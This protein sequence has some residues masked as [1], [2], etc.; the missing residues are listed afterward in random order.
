MAMNAN[1]SST[2]SP[3]PAQTLGSYL[4]R[5]QLRLI[6]QGVRPGSDPFVENCFGAILVVDV[7]G[8]TALTERFAAQGVAGAE[9]LSC[10]LNRYFGQIADIITACGGDIVAFAGDSAL[11]M[12]TG[13]H[14]D[15]A[16]NIVR[17]TQAA[18]NIQ[19]E[20]DQYEAVRGVLLRQRAGI[21]CGA[22][23]LM[24]L[25]GVS[26]R[27]QF[28][29]TGSPIAQAS[30]ANQNAQSGEVF[31]SSEAWNLVRSRVRGTPLPSGLVRATEVA[32]SEP[33]AR[34]FAEPVSTCDAAESFS[35]LSHYVPAVVADR[36]RAGQEQWIAEFRN[37]SMLF[38]NLAESRID[39]PTAVAS[40]HEHLRCIQEVLERFEGT[41]YQFL[42]DDKGLTAVCAFGLPPQAHENDPRRAVEAGIA[43]RDELASRGV[44]TSAGIATGTVF[45][46]VYGSASRRQYTTLGSI[47][48]LSARLMQS[49]EGSILCDHPTSHAARSTS[50]LRFQSKGEIRV[51]G[52]SARIPV[53]APALRSEA[54][55]TAVSATAS[56]EPQLMV[57]RAA[58]RAALAEALTALVERRESRCIIVEGEAGVGKSCL[59][60]HLFQEIA[61]TNRNGHKITCWRAAADSIQQST[62]YHVWRAVFREVFQPVGVLVQAQRDHILAQLATE[63]ELLPLAP[64]LNVVLPLGIPENGTT[65]ALAGQARAAN[66][67][68][69]LVSILKSA[70]IRSPTVVILEDAHW[71]DS[72]SLRLALLAAQQIVPLLLVLSARP[73]G[74]SC[75]AELMALLASPSCRHLVLEVLD[76]D[77]ALQMVCQRLGVNRLPAEVARFID[78]RA[79]GHPLFSEQL[80]Y[81]LRDTGL[82]K[83]T[84]GRCQIA[85]TSSGAPLDAALSAMRFPSTVEG[86]I[87]SRLDRMPTPQQLTVKV[88]SVLG[89]NFRLSTLSEIYPVESDRTQLPAHL[90]QMEKLDLIHRSRLWLQTRDYSGRRLQLH[91][92]RPAPPA[93]SVSG[94]MVRRR[95]R[96]QLA[97]PL[98]PVG[99]S[100]EPRRSRA[101]G[102]ALLLRGGL[103]G[104]EQLCQRGGGAFSERSLEP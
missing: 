48:N 79:G 33:V 46:G 71:F 64:L 4:P 63:P 104:T 18:L 54:A 11:A 65:A 12:W 96:Q 77:L 7:S 45:C 27:W 74:E 100:L 70:V 73:L 16:A 58:E 13:E 67:E 42:M 19:S 62:P 43:M 56:S 34:A 85:E 84:E 59:L 93:A 72:S 8:F 103:P 38:L 10:I 44:S 17:A 3:Q 95:I 55:P 94:R 32:A 6:V 35:V 97:G 60:E 98:S 24:E 86:V 37:L 61:T 25:G 99:P 83:I 14:S 50:T 47:I 78:R 21:G 90:D 36:L 75:P 68:H 22:L 102:R 28:I 2:P 69:L 76:S 66:T 5:Y 101:Q 39:S 49:A 80:A 89:Q 1:S 52:R 29:V 53:F 15:L 30:I 26:G 20:L 91:S 41:L 51:K 40:L 9:E 81:A 92:L 87:T 31:L 23:Q 57:G 82:M 88:A